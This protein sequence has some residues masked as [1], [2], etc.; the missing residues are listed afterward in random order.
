[1]TDTTVT[2][3]LSPKLHQ[4]QIVTKYILD[5]NTN[6][7][8][9]E[10]NHKY[11]KKTIISKIVKDDW[12]KTIK[13]FQGQ[14]K[15]SGVSQ[16]HITMITDVAENQYQDI[17]P[18]T[19]VDKRVKPKFIQKYRTDESLA[20]AAI[21]GDEPYFAVATNGGISLE[22]SIHDF[23]PPSA[24]SYMNRAYVFKSKEEFDDLVENAKHETIDSLYDKVKKQWQKYDAADD[25]EISLCAA[26]TIFTYFQDS[27]GMTH[28]LF[29]VGSP[30][31]GKSNRLLVFNFLAYR[32]F[33]ST[34]VTPSNIYR[35]LG[36]QQEGQGTICED[37]ADDLEES[38][39]KMKIYKS[40]YTSGFKVARNE[41]SINGGMSQSAYC[42]YGF[43]VFSAERL[44]DSTKAKALV[45]RLI[46]LKCLSAIP[47]FESSRIWRELKEWLPGSDILYKPLSFESSQFGTISQKQITEILKS[48][49]SA[50]SPSHNSNKAKLT[51]DKSILDRLDGKYNTDL[52]VE[53]SESTEEDLESE[54]DPTHDPTQQNHAQNRGFEEDEEDEEDVQ[55]KGV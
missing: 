41:D 27:L 30:D 25:L 16:E 43:K 44:P 40:G 10:L 23:M 36:S 37:E 13:K 8:V 49:F 53:V 5:L 7:L 48:D 52:N 47:E 19:I 6:S 4:E 32:N 51:F 20:E 18:A 34:D 15:Q 29:F 50:K 54:D 14:M 31:S 42:T 33:M 12:T 11:N 38:P 39:E 3:E 9:L 45:Q 1:M 17:L 55:Q 26:D 22:E 2:L 35:F 24:T 21:I 46:E 28:Y